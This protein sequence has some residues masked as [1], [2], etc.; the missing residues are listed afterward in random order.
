M[1]AVRIIVD[2]I[3]KEEIRNWE[4]IMFMETA[5]TYEDRVYSEQRQM[6]RKGLKIN[7]KEVNKKFS[8]KLRMIHDIRI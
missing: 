4:M 1:D 7:L 8:E 3:C 2:I 6:R 5:T